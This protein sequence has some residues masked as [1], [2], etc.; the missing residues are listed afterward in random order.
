MLLQHFFISS[1]MLLE[2]LAIIFEKV[3]VKMLYEIG[4]EFCK[5]VKT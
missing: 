1:H 5:V 3:F 2:L 4:F